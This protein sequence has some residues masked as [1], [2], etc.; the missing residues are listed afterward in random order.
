MLKK[1]AIA[2]RLAGAIGFWPAGLFAATL[3]GSPPV[4]VAVM[5]AFPWSLWI[6]SHVLDA[7]EDIRRA[8][9]RDAES[10]FDVV[11]TQSQSKAG[12]SRR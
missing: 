1:H 3:T 10:T 6:L 5:V 8:A 4:G 12:Q 7:L 9:V 2:L 11:P